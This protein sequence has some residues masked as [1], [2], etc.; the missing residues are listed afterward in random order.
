MGI[1]LLTATEIKV[2]RLNRDTKTTLHSK[3]IT[4]DLLWQERHGGFSGKV[5]YLPNEKKRYLAVPM[6][7]YNVIGNHNKVVML[8]EG[9]GSIVTRASEEALGGRYSSKLFHATLV[10]DANALLDNEDVRKRLNLTYLFNAGDLNY[11]S[12]IIGDNK[13]VRTFMEAMD[14]EQASLDMFGEY[15]KLGKL[16]CIHRKSKNAAPDSVIFGLLTATGILYRLE[17][18]DEKV[19]GYAAIGCIDL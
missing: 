2:D 5:M 19:I 14:P 16:V 11:P 6:Q 3:A 18:E 8:T 4:V 7:F 17:V 10:D 12:V 1:N 15:A 9:F 13:K